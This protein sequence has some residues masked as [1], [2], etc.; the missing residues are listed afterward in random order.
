MNSVISKNKGIVILTS[1][2][3]TVASLSNVIMTLMLAKLFDTI[4]AS[5]I[6][7]FMKQSLYLVIMWVIIITFNYLAGIKKAEAIKR[8]NNTVRNTILETLVDKDYENY[9][10]EDTGAYVSWL[11]NDI[12]LIENNG[13]ENIFE[14]VSQV[15][16]LV[17]SLC[18]L[19]YI[20]YYT[21]V[22]VS[23][24]GVIMTLIPKLVNK[25]IQEQ[26]T[27][28]SQEQEK[29]L[30]KTKENVMGYEVLYSYN[31]LDVFQEKIL[32]G[33]DVLE[34]SKYK[35]KQLNL[36]LEGLLTITNII[37]QLG[38]IFFTGCLSILGY[39]TVGSIIPTGNLAG[40]LF[41]SFGKMISSIT[42]IKSTSPI[43]EKFENNRIEKDNTS[44]YN[45]KE[46][47]FKKSIELRNVSFSYN[48]SAN[49]LNNVSVVFEKGK[50]YA[51]VGE[52][53]CGK[54]TLIK[55]ITGYLKDYDG[56]IYIDNIK[57]EE[58][59]P[60][61]IRNSMS[62]ISQNSYMFKDTIKN[63][64]QLYEIFDKENLDKAI[65]DSSL[66][67]FVDSLEDK[68]NSIIGED[69]GNISGGQKQRISIARALI[70]NK[71]ILI[72]D[73]G[74]SALDK[75]NATNVEDRLLNDP[76]LTVIFVTHKIDTEF[77]D[78]FDKVINLDEINT[79]MAT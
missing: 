49:V 65:K 72:L 10:D 45:K 55:L 19:V 62:Y 1:I 58:Y 15:S 77:L 29:F 64:I 28:M 41:S 24:L 66:N 68:C 4:V 17:F 57:K 16:T 73:E 30:S 78:K 23:F 13:F 69:G 39:T 8:M 42:I 6:D 33:A 18:G 26:S 31:L 35:F 2:L 5:D 21:L 79:V 20:H 12:T 47:E 43:F 53:G 9:K 36:I 63:N 56:E 61:S 40:S 34:K 7:R 52:S 50:K 11:S 71:K 25:K 74:T 60:D 70:R 14:I 46:L 67:E 54:T 37:S 38:L 44:S 75:E 22:A 51:I 76:N 3:L 48:G 59:R 32:Q 27:K